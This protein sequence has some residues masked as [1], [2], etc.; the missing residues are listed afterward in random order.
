MSSDD[1]DFNPD[2]LEAQSA[3][4]EYDSEPTTTSSEDSDVSGSGSD[5]DRKREEKKKKKE[6]AKAKKAKRKES[7]GGEKKPRTQKTKKM[8]K[9]P[10]QPKKNMSAYFL[11]MQANRAEISAKNKGAGVAEIAKI[12]GAQWKELEGTE[13][14][15]E[16]TRRPLKT[17]KGMRRN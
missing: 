4:E 17:R 16:W 7:G 1:E 14:K 9:L 3:K 13:E 6:E 2:T 8:T 5:A 12:A 11:W 10:G 15:K